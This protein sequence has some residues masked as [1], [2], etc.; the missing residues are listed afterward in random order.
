MRFGGKVSAGRKTRRPQASSQGNVRQSSRL[1]L[2]RDC[3]GSECR[4]RGEARYRHCC[5]LP[6]RRQDLSDNYGTNHLF[7]TPLDAPFEGRRWDG[8]K[9]KKKKKDSSQHPG[10][11]SCF[12]SRNPRPALA[13]YPLLDE[14]LGP[15]SGFAMGL[16]A[17]VSTCLK[18][19]CASRF[20]VGFSVLLGRGNTK[21]FPYT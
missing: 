21:T 20:V 12:S 5:C 18:A 9:K 15:Y 17:P 1:G 3:H 16:G 11:V 13:W 10:P 14:A 4:I 2:R 7:D 8:L 6:L 19:R